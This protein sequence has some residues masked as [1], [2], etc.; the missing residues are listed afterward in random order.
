MW[1]MTRVPTEAG[2]KMHYFKGNAVAIEGTRSVI[3]HLMWSLA[4]RGHREQAH[5]SVAGWRVDTMLAQR[6]RLT[7]NPPLA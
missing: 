7:T 4:A 6:R 5:L 1:F 2:E 3:V